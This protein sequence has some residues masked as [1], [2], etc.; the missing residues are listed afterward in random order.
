[1]LEE[2]VVVLPNL[3]QL[4]V[5]MGVQICASDDAGAEIEKLRSSMPQLTDALMSKLQSFTS[6]PI[7]HT[8]RNALDFPRSILLFLGFYHL[9]SESARNP[10]LR[11]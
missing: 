4:C 2:N 3:I 9:S 8:I 11:I 1:M 6:L 5:E 7:R 10:L